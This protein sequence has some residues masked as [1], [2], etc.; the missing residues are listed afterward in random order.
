MKMLPAAFNAIANV[1]GMASFIG[2]PP[3]FFLHNLEL[4]EFV[5][6][7]E[8]ANRDLGCRRSHSGLSYST[9]CIFVNKEKTS[10][11]GNTS[12]RLG[13]E[14][15]LLATGIPPCLSV[16]VVKTFP[17]PHCYAHLLLP[18]WIIHPQPHP[19]KNRRPK[20]DNGRARNLIALVEK[21]LSGR[22]NFQMLSQR[23][24]PA[25]GPSYKT[26]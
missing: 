12:R 2:H 14:S 11:P 25:E 20:V 23:T 5:N 26:R 7:A 13:V 9:R 10:A 17:Q 8:V 24:V 15:R 3:H 18:R 22:K 4:V 16:S 6:R 21:I 19:K 1:S